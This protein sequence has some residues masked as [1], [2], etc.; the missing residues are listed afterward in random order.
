M[1]SK[2]EDI[3][4]LKRTIIQNRMKKRIAEQ[5]AAVSDEAIPRAD[6]ESALPLSWS[7]QRLWFL[8]RLDRSA[9]AAYH[10]SSALRLNG[11]LDHSALRSSLNRIVA[12]HENLR[13]VFVNENGA[14]RQS[15]LDADIGFSLDEVDLTSCDETAVDEII[16][17]IG[18]EEAKTPFDLS[19]GPLLRG[20]LLIFGEE[21]HVLIVTQHHI[22]SDG[23]ST[24]IL[25]REVS[26]LYTAFSHGKEDP[27]PELPIQFAD[28]AA[29][30]RDWLKGETL[31]NQINFWKKHLGGA[32]PLLQIPTDRPRTENRS[33]RG[34]DVA[35]DI[36]DAVT[37]AL[38]DISRRHGTTLFMTV[39]AAWASL[40]FRLSGQQEIVVGTPVTNR[41]R[42][43][44]ENLIGF[45]VNTVAIRIDFS[46][47]PTVSGLL[48]QVREST[49]NAYA[50][51]DLP[52]EKVVEVLQPER[53][54]SH[55][56]IFQVLL[57]MGTSMLRESVELPG[58]RIEQ[59][60]TPY[61]CA[62]FDL[63]IAFFDNGKDLI[64]RLTYASDIFDRQTAQR[65]SEYLVCLLAGMV[66]E[67]HGRISGLIPVF[68]SSYRCSGRNN[69]G[70]LRHPDPQDRQ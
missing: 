14:P 61:N 7:Q 52:F 49:L 65:F 68:Q 26:A 6:R 64:G 35:I 53:S 28:Y 19:R 55:S 56:P 22:I 59:L 40:L 66:D 62:H 51:Q 67:E 18:E 8:D 50:N 32:P 5:K 36:P 31:D 1:N 39:L 69:S 13:T 54:L 38:R 12:R 15:I 23:W 10:L 44:L 57:N 2:M 70:C 3:D 27:L 4:S 9:S 33:Y 48:A 21:D 45:F 42:R 25:V 47:D 46:D 37:A 41:G 17:R 30:Q 20:K 60:K 58:L 11:R 34:D 63:D 24:S 43:E 16:E 29:W